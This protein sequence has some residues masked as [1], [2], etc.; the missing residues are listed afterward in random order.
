MKLCI[1]KIRRNKFLSLKLCNRYLCW[2]SVPKKRGLCNTDETECNADKTIRPGNTRL[3][4]VNGPERDVS[5]RDTPKGK[6]K[7]SIR[8]PRTK[9]RKAL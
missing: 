8:Q 4:E 1:A 7:R 3:R 2:H 9:A 5:L 6:G